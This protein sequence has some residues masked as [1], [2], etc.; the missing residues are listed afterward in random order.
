VEAQS[1]LKGVLFHKAPLKCFN[2]LVSSGKLKQSENS[3]A[4]ERENA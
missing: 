1:N 4:L 3:E 2:F